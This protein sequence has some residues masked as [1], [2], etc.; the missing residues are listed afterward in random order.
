MSGFRKFIL[1]GNIVDL[2]IAL[3]IDAWPRNSTR[4][5]AESLLMSRERLSARDEAIVSRNALSSTDSTSWGTSRSST[6]T[7]PF[8]RSTT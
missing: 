3:V 2:A 8:G 1:H 6:R 4:R 5:L 7:C